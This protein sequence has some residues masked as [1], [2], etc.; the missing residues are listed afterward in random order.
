[1]KTNFILILILIFSLN[2]KSQSHVVEKKITYFGLHP[3]QQHILDSL[4]IPYLPISE[5]NGMNDYGKIEV[6]K[7]KISK[8]NKFF[9]K[10]EFVFSPNENSPSIRFSS[11]FRNYEFSNKGD[12]LYFSILE[13]FDFDI[14]GVSTLD[15]NE[16]NNIYKTIQ[17]IE[18]RCD[19][20]NT[21]GT[22]VLLG[23]QKNVMKFVY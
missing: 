20:N 22:M 7:K 10:N 16:S 12:L 1:M 14:I 15:L 4:K 21:Y 9:D 5:R 3:A 6:D 8:F 11:F 23:D 18:Y 13:N 17:V 2:L 19:K